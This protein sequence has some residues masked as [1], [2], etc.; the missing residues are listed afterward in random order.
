MFCFI[1]TWVQYIRVC[2]A[3][4]SLAA[5]ASFSKPRDVS[6]GE[7]RSESLCLFLPILT[8]P[9]AKS[10]H[11]FKN[12][13]LIQNLVVTLLISI[14]SYFS[15]HMDFNILILIHIWKFPILIH[16]SDDYSER[17]AFNT[18]HHLWRAFLRNLNFSVL[19]KLAGYYDLLLTEDRVHDSLLGWPEGIKLRPPKEIKSFT[20]W[21]MDDNNHAH[22]CNAIISVC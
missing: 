5:V 21:L 11:L 3:Y 15:L 7:V 22:L 9:F 2:Y 16:T 18:A 8:H 6:S 20:T 1:P 12:L 4:L 14:C 13:V 10:K 19:C 17:G